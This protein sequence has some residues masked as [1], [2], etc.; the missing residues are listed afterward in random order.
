MDSTNAARAANRFVDRRATSGRMPG[1]ER[2]QF[3]NSYSR[4]SAEAQELARAIDAYKM[5]HCRKFINYEEMLQ[6]LQSIGYTK[7]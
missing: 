7:S 1:M 4:L 2:R 3:T 5:E 6:I